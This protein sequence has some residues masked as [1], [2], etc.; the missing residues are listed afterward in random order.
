[1]CSP[2]CRFA[3]QINMTRTWQ[4]SMMNNIQAEIG[5]CLF[6]VW[7]IIKRCHHI[8]WVYN[9]CTIWVLPL[10]MQNRPAGQLKDCYLWFDTGT[11][12]SDVDPPLGTYDIVVGSSDVLGGPH[13]EHLP[14]LPISERL[15]TSHRAKVAHILCLAH[16]ICLQ[17]INWYF[18]DDRR[19]SLYLSVVL[20]LGWSVH[21]Y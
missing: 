5:I 19:Y 4:C 10:W 8:I 3:L 13:T 11:K 12:P 2:L 20:I 1:M 16:F 9:F 15:W 14:D 21:W 17:H 7:P 6:S 18:P